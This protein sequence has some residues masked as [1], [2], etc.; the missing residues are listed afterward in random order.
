MKHRLARFWVA[1]GRRGWLLVFLVT[2]CAPG[3][4]VLGTGTPGGTPPAAISSPFFLTPTPGAAAVTPGAPTLFPATPQVIV[5]TAVA[6]GPVGPGSTPAAG[7]PAPTSLAPTPLSPLPSGLG[8]TAARYQLSD[9]FSPIFF[10]DPDQYPVA[11]PLEDAEVLRRFAAVEGNP[12]EYGAILKHLKLE[13][14]PALTLQQKT[15]VYQEHK[16][17]ESIQLKPAAGEYAF[18]LRSGEGRTGQLVEG[19]IG[20]S[21]AV[22]ITRQ[23]PTPL[24]CPICLAAGA[25]I[26]TPTGPR[27]VETLRPGMPVW[28]M[29]RR[30]ERRQGVVLQVIARPLPGQALLANLVLADGR[31]L[32]VSAGHPTADGRTVGRLSAGDSLDGAR[33]AALELVPYEGATYDLL[34]SGETGSYWANGIL[35]GSTLAR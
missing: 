10:C 32:V 34:P 21:G 11:R 23:D 3:T 17:L 29:D 1:V 2:A 27:R 35:L 7:T 5:A 15:A 12:E 26:D 6:G 8:P 31:A 24:T 4:G 19:T 28:T 14:T 18:A 16:R 30:G 20:G 33:I 25:Q 9:R 22:K 13:G